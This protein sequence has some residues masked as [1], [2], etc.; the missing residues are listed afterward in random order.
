[1]TPGSSTASVKAAC[2]MM[3]RGEHLGNDVRDLVEGRPAQRTTFD[4]EV[5]VATSKESRRAIH[6]WERAWR[7]SQ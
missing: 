6:D 2:A 3:A 4:V 5:M 7:R 1:M